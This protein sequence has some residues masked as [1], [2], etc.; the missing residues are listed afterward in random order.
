MASEEIVFA[1]DLHA[2]RSIYV[3]HPNMIDDSQFALHQIATYCLNN[4]LPLVLLGDNFNKR[5]PGPDVINWFLESLANVNVYFIQGQHDMQPVLAWPEVVS[6]GPRIKKSLDQRNSKEKTPACIEVSGIKLYGFDFLPRTKLQECLKL[7]PSDC[8]ILCLHALIKDVM[9]IDEAW[10][11]DTDWIPTHVDTTVL[12]DWHGL[13][14]SGITNGR[15]WLYTGSS[16]MQSVTEPTEKTFLVAKRVCPDS[17]GKDKFEFE[18]IPLKTRPYIF[19]D[20]RHEKELETWISSI[21]K[22]CKEA[23]EEATSLGIPDSVTRPFVVLRYN[24]GIENAYQKIMN[25][26]GTLIT[27][28]I[29]YFHPMPNRSFVS[30][31][32]EDCALSKQISVAD[33]IAEL[34]DR[35]LSPELHSLV[36]DLTHT[37]DPEEVITGFKQRH[38]VLSNPIGN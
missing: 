17:A 9:G 2:A 26:I 38:D 14:Q 1:G 11:L 15:K 28:G 4:N 31:G 29:I 27:D 32:K 35:E 3:T 19:A 20:V 8:E 13:P 23:R 25:T 34:V 6:F 24:V 21:V 22:T 7:V 30:E 5:F 12:G 18:R 10:H 33:A 36:T 37:A 16:S